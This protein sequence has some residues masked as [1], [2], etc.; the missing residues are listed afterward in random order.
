MLM[1]YD[2]IRRMQLSHVNISGWQAPSKLY[3]HGGL[4]V[5]ARATR[6]PASSVHMDNTL[7]HTRKCRYTSVRC[8]NTNALYLSIVLHFFPT[9]SYS[10]NAFKVH[11][12]WKSKRKVKEKFFESSAKKRTSVWIHTSHEG[13][14]KIRMKM[15]IET[16]FLSKLGL[17]DL[18]TSR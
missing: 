1:N 13:K 10:R 12:D 14:T 9:I 11:R 7:R 4:F 5:S 6:D 15:Y 3:T 2:Y 17:G 18:W 8:M 16:F